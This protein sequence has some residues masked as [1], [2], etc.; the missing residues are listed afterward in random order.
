MAV[1]GTPGKMR[2]GVE[3]HAVFGH[4]ALD[5]A[6][7]GFV[8][9]VGPPRRGRAVADEGW[10]SVKWRKSFC[11]SARPCGPSFPGPVRKEADGFGNAGF[12]GVR[13]VRGESRSRRRRG[14]LHGSC[15]FSGRARARGALTSRPAGLLLL[16]GAALGFAALAVLL[17]VGTALAVFFLS[18]PALAVGL[19]LSA[20]AGFRTCR[21]WPCRPG[22]R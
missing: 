19:F 8:E 7:R 9:A 1:V 13:S 18:P 21:P 5:A 3:G 20:R 6:E 2:F 15:V 17:L 22:R 12:E 14:V 10:R 16:V 4:E 11:P